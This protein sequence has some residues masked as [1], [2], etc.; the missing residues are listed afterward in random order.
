[1]S[2]PTAP[3]LSVVSQNHRFQRILCIDL[4]NEKCVDYMRFE[5]WKICSLCGKSHWNFNKRIRGL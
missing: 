1:V 3:P 4:C 5:T 2:Q